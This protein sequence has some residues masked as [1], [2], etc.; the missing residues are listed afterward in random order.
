[1]EL[2]P[3]SR[4]VSSRPDVGLLSCSWVFSEGN[5]LGPL[6][7]P[8]RGARPSRAA[9]PARRPTHRAA[10]PYAS[11]RHSCGCSLCAKGLP[12]LIASH[13]GPSLLLSLGCDRQQQNAAVGPWHEAARAEAL[14][15]AVARRATSGTP[16]MARPLSGIQPCSTQGGTR[17][18]IS[19]GPAAL[20]HSAL[21]HGH[22]ALQH[23]ARHAAWDQPR[24][25]RS[26]AFRPAARS[27]AR[28][29]GTVQAPSALRHSALQ[30]AAQHA[31]WVPPRP[32]RSLASSPRPRH[33]RPHP[34][35]LQHPPSPSQAQQG[36]AAARVCPPHQVR[37]SPPSRSSSEG[38]Q[39]TWPA[40][41][42]RAGA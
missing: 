9:A 4:A 23:A 19:P 28:G 1:M 6:A 10:L 24:P 42:A 11:L 14:S 12:L 26:L 21:Q 32:G 38:R 17:P 37:R 22:S 27:A 5:R 29:P 34:H 18:G 16:P 30:H 41:A 8:P 39:W 25:G 33:H 20:R 31:A 35:P 15:T 2:K 13:R 40:S 7:G 36:V 3:L